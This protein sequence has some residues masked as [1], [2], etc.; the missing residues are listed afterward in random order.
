[1]DVVYTREGW[2]KYSLRAELGFTCKC[3]LISHTCVNAPTRPQIGCSYCQTSS[4]GN[5]VDNNQ[6]SQDKVRGRI[7]GPKQVDDQ[8]LVFTNIFRWLIHQVTFSPLRNQV[9]KKTI[10]GVPQVLL[11][12]S[13]SS[14]HYGVVLPL[15]MPHS[16]VCLGPTAKFM[17][18]P[19]QPLTIP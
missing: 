7:C 6:E 1:M 13:T 15:C 16:S 10:Y 8:I 5:W 19:W 18:S 11:G 14:G 12:C 9:W 2:G 3:K 4:A 17:A